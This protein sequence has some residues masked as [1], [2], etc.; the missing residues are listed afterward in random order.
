[1]TDINN[2]LDPVKKVV[3]ALKEKGMTEEDLYMNVQDCKNE[4]AEVINNLG[5]YDQVKYLLERG[6]NPDNWG[7]EIFDD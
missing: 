7:A 5:M 3:K 1:M 6:S 4:E 2:I